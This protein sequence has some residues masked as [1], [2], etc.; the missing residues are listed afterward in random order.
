M[1][2]LTPSEIKRL[3]ENR[4]HAEVTLTLLTMQLSPMSALQM[5]ALTFSTRVLSPMV[6]FMMRACRIPVGSSYPMSVVTVSLL[7]PMLHSPMN[8]TS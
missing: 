4:C 7:D 6:E 3:G 2:T 5:N 8:C 1:R